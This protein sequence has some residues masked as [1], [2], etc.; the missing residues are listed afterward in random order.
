M[1]PFALIPLGLY[2]L[3]ATFDGEI[4]TRNKASA[5]QGP[6]QKASLTKSIPDLENITGYEPTRP[7]T[8]E[9]ATTGGLTDP[10]VKAAIAKTLTMEVEQN[11][12]GLMQSASSEKLPKPVEENPGQY[13]PKTVADDDGGYSAPLGLKDESHND[14][15]K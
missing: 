1:S 8:N 11:K 14:W 2:A 15:M 5:A 4:D 3:A 10:I 12:Q 13:F 7:N 9:L 6:E